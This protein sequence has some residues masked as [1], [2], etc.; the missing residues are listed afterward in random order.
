MKVLLHLPTEKEYNDELVKISR[1]WSAVFF[2]L[3]PRYCINY[4]VG[5]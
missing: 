3:A 4:K 5:N 1:K 2:E